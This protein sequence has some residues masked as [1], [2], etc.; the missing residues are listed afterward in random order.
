MLLWVFFAV[1]TGLAVLTA[2]V[3]L[4]RRRTGPAPERAHDIAVYRDQLAAVDGDVARGLLR[5]EE[6][7]AARLEISRRLLAAADRDGGQAGPAPSPAARTAQAAA[8]AVAIIAVSLGGYLAL[9]S[10]GL[11]GQPLAER[12]A[13]PLDQ[14]DGELLIARIEAHL[15]DNPQ[16]GRG[17]DVIAPIYLRLG[18]HEAAAR[19]FSNAIR[20]V[21]ASAER[22]SGLGEAL[23]LAN[24]GIVTAEAREALDRAHALD[25]GL[26]RP[27]FYIALSLEQD[28]RLGEA[29]EA[30]RGLLAD[31]PAGA[32][33][34]AAVA[35]RLA[36]V[37]QELGRTDATAPP[38]AGMPSDGPDEAAER[39][40]ARLA[41]RLAADGHDLDGWLM[42]AR[43]YAVL[44]RTA[45]ARAALAQARRHFSARQEALERIA[46]TARALGLDRAAPAGGD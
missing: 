43:S 35:G 44:G 24:D 9:G 46:E 25:A 31:A 28:G 11:P 45:E 19:A 22:L 42:L 14:Q 32:P 30:W 37:E 23:V 16:D 39:M 17:W 18:R 2:L 8:L 12:Q 27:R 10:P 20:I 4:A 29:A 38:A 3:P 26:T 40:V 13:K 36:A 5:A 34:R 1:M 6:A 41:E 33:W 15:R 7:A 21:G